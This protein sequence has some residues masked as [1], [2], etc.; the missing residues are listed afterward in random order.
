MDI[1]P[2][3]DMKNKYGLKKFKIKA[4]GLSIRFL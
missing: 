1:E 2:G 3:I 4:L